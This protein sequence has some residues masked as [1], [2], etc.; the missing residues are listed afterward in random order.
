MILQYDLV[1]YFF[2]AFFVATVLGIIASI[3]YAGRSQ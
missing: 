1:N 2:I 3:I